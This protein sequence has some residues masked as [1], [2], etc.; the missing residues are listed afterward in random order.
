M[1]PANYNL[2]A[3]EAALLLEEGGYSGPQLFERTVALTWRY[4]TLLD[5]ALETYQKPDNPP[6]E[7]SDPGES[8]GNDLSSRLEETTAR[9]A[10][11][12]KPD[13]P[14]AEASSKNQPLIRLPTRNNPLTSE[15]SPSTSETPALSASHH[16]DQ[17]P[18]Q[19]SQPALKPKVIFSTGGITNG[20]VH[21]ADLSLI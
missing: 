1:L 15:D 11:N 2:P 7:Q 8:P 18:S 10:A 13:T 12:L 5:E 9:D 19:S 21:S 4:R 14:E 6:T 16:V 3:R 20:A 17:I